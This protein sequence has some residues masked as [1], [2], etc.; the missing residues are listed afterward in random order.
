MNKFFLAIFILNVLLT[1]NIFAQ[2]YTRE[3][4]IN[5]YKDIAIKEMKRTGVPASI[6]LAQGILESNH[7]NSTLAKKANN[8]FGIKCHDDWKGPSIKHNDDK[9]KE[10][11]R[12]YRNANESF[13]DHSDFL[14]KGS[15]YDFLFKLKQTDYVGWAKGLQKAGYATNKKYAKNLIKIIEEYQLYQYDD[16]KRK[17]KNKDEKAYIVDKENTININRE[18]YL[19]NNVKYIIAKSGDTYKDLALKCNMMP[20]EIYKY[21]DLPDDANIAP[22]QKIYIQPKKN[23]AER[24]KSYHTVVSGETMY[25]ISQKYAIKLKKLYKLNDIPN[26]TPLE[27]GQKIKIR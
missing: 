9:R 15:R 23:K 7:G 25:T 12:K 17:E 6:T 27:T 14:V 11:F 22:G 13:K 3:E 16:F 24:G 2:R 21:N 19:N 26:G 5:Q 10:C 4:Y 20:W 8:H 18:I 1:K